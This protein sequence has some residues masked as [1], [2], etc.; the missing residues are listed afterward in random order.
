[1]NSA[2]YI[3]SLGNQKR[4]AEVD[5]VLVALLLDIELQIYY[6]DGT[7]LAKMKFNTDSKRKSIRLYLNAGGVFDTI[8]DKAEIKIAGICQAIVLDVSVSASLVM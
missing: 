4:T 8:Y 6:F 1:M 5:A 3:Q 2:E 7:K